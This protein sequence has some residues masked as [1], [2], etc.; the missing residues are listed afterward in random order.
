MKKIDLL[1][2]CTLVLLCLFGQGANPNKD[3]DNFGDKKTTFLFRFG[4]NFA[5]IHDPE[6]SKTD[7]DEYE[8]YPLKPGVM[9][10][11]GVNFAFNKYV[12]LQPELLFVQKGDKFTKKQRDGGDKASYKETVTN[13]YLELPILV[14]G[15]YSNSKFEA[16]GSFGP[17]I[18][19]WMSSME[20][21]V[22]KLN[23]ERD[24]NKE[25]IDLRKKEGDYYTENRIDVGINMG[26]GA[27][28]KLNNGMVI[29]MELRGNI[30][31]TGL[32]R[33]TKDAH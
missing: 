1:L 6:F 31:L 20:K 4:T 26:V 32:E 2:T 21:E 7:L 33:R 17:S 13:N 19:F 5:R 8:H 25:K 14:N 24:V 11:I 27:G 29:G 22:A 10:G 15:G 23:G 28:Y 9:T 12:S 18:G 3:K 30:G 16:F